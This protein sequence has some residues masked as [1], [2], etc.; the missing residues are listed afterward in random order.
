[1]RQKK[2]NIVTLPLVIAA[3]A[4]E[5]AMANVSNSLLPQNLSPWGMFMNA[6]IVVKAVMIGLAFASLV[7]WTVWLAKTIE[8][9]RETSKA[10][11]RIRMLESGP[12]LIE[13]ARALRQRQ[14]RGRADRPHHGARGEPVRRRLRRRF[15]RTR[16]VADRTRAARDGAA[17]CARHRHP[18]HDRLDGAVRRP[19]RHRLGHHELRSSAFPKSKTTSLAVVAPGIAEALLA[20][21]LGLVAAIPA[22]VIYNHLARSISRLSRTAR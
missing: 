2:C 8:L 10:K 18:R 17:D 19:V 13:A 11:K 14:G 15:P 20:T 7:T 21:A 5:T 12:S 3:T 4:P 22:V 6:D 1:M 16:R 9:A